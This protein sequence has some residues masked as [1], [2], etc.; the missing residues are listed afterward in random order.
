MKHNS[1]GSGQPGSGIKKGLTTEVYLFIL[2]IVIM[3]ILRL[4][5]ADFYS[6]NNV[7]STF[8][9]FSYLL[10]GAVG[11]NLIII[12]GNIDVSA[13]A[14]ISVVGIA[15]AF[16]GKTNVPFEVFLPVGMAVGAG[17]S[18]MNGI[19]ITKLRIPSIVATLATTQLFAG[20][21][22][23]VV[24]GAIY[25][26]PA[27]FTWLAFN[28]KLFGIIPSS[29]LFMIIIAVIAIIFMKY[30]RF[31]KKLYAIGNNANAAK[32]AGVN[33]NKTVVK[34]FVIAGALYG[35]AGTLIV[36][37]GQRVTMTM[38][39][40]LEMT[41]I[42][43]VVLGGTSIAGGSGKIIGTVV[44]AFILS[45]ISPAMNYMGLSSDWSDAVMGAI[46]LVS[47][48][49]SQI[50]VMTEKNKLNTMKLNCNPEVK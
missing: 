44:G 9:Y 2:V 3:L 7:M 19:F 36:T 31:A 5:A 33:V 42:A 45:L 14:I 8:N 20:I 37:A 48:I 15:V 4:F 13:G 50:A 26:L 21:L 11:M 30:S 43:A 40:G 23:L 35:V 16:V 41:L 12:T 32:L 22:P 10:I 28:A 25:D 47:V 46:I 34:G 6:L 27:N 1:D 39:S 24:D 38:G 17:L 49:V 18:F 29:V